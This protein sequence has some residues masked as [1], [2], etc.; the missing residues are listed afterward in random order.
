MSAPREPARGSRDGNPTDIGWFAL[1][2]EDLRAHGGRLDAPGFWAVAVHR[3]GNWRMRVREPWRAP[4]TLLYRAAFQAIR[5]GF[6]IDLPYDTK[7]GR[8]VRLEQPGAVVVGA[9]AI[10]DD[11]V[12]RGS[13]ILGVRR[14]KGDDGR[15]GD[16]DKPI[17]EHGVEIGARACVVGAVI[18]GHDAVI[19]ANT[20]VPM[21]VP[22]HAVAL[23]VPARLVDL[24]RLVAPRD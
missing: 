12:I 1:V 16:G 24:R 10:G 8:R 15:D 17:I 2:R 19:L 11:V 6:G 9:R 20:V 7:L 14:R 13:A 23:G 4:L 18:V 3:F 5:C 22:P 21:D